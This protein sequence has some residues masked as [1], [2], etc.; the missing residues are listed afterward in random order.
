MAGNKSWVLPFLTT[1]EDGTERHDS[2]AAL[3]KAS[4]LRT[5]RR[6]KFLIREVVGRRTRGG[7]RRKVVKVLLGAAA[8]KRDGN[9]VIKSRRVG[10]NQRIMSARSETSWQQ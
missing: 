6:R 5:K 4:K 3:S 2:R 10:E 8:T 1:Q 9:F 7:G